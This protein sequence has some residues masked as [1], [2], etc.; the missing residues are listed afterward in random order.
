MENGCLDHGLEQLHSS[1]LKKFLSFPFYFICSFLAYNLLDSKN[2]LE[3]S[4]K[5]HTSLKVV[6]APIHKMNLDITAVFVKHPKTLLGQ[7]GSILFFFIQMNLP[8][9]RNFHTKFM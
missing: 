9:S 3:I 2:L 4:L 7:E 5:L 8:C 1:F 6:R